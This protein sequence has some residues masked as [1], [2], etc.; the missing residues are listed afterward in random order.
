M[1]S[2]HNWMTCI[3]IIMLFIEYIIKY[4]KLY[5]II[6]IMDQ[7]FMDH[8]FMDHKF[9]SA[10]KHYY[11]L[12]QQYE[13]SLQKQKLNIMSKTLLSKRE[14]RKKIMQL[15]PKCINCKKPGGT[16]FSNTNDRLKAVC[17]SSDP[18]NLNIDLLKAKYMN[19]QEEYRLYKSDLEQY[20]TSIIMTKLDF[21]FGYKS[22]EETL[23]LFEKRSLEIAKITDKMF[24][25]ENSIND[26]INNK[27]TQQ[28]I[29]QLEKT[30][31]ENIYE[32]KN[33]YKEY[34]V[35]NTSEMIN[36]MVEIYITKIRPLVEEIRNLNYMNTRV[37]HSEKIKYMYNV[38]AS[39]ENI[40]TLVEE[41]YTIDKMEL[42]EGKNMIVSYT[43]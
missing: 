16:I 6:N 21:L 43:F 8:K 14:K 28:T 7:K 4:N 32:I 11:K 26:I 25:L 41:P 12:K 13:T 31:Y 36:D 20:K 29:K 42:A 34:L 35:D 19:S 37:E 17:G 27:E 18:C 38:K 1:R 23:S 10:M 5:I 2:S 3:W 22:E 33:I 15:Q 24:Q 40:Y 30:L 9:M 39:D